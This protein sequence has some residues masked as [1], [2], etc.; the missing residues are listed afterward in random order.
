VLDGA[1]I[2]YDGLEP[3]DT[4]GTSGADLVF[5]LPAGADNVELVDLGGGE[6]RLQSTDVAPTFEEHNFTDPGSAGSITINLGSGADSFIL[7]DL[8]GLAASLEVNGGADDDTIIATGNTNITLTDGSLTVDGTAVVI[9]DFQSAVLVGG[10]SATV[11]N[12]G[13]F[14]GTVATVELSGIPVW[15]EQGPGPM[16]RGQTRGPG[17]RPRR[18][19][20]QFDRQA[21]GESERVLRRDG[22]WRRMAQRRQRSRAVRDRRVGADRRR[23]SGAGQSDRHHAG[24]SRPDRRDRRAYGFGRGSRRQSRALQ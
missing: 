21:S 17:R 11:L 7:P 19:R 23:R 10:T 20:D 1:T 12:S 4:T 18:R 22:R 8:T 24:Q 5:N 9:S 14:S 13:G 15:Q 2:E 6:Y 16:E 3:I